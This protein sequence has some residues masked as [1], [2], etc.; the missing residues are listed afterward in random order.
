MSSTSASLAEMHRW[1]REHYEQMVELGVFDSEPRVE[2]I[3]GYIID[4][5]P[6]SSTHAAVVH[7]VT[8]ALDRVFGQSYYSI[9]VQAPLALD[10]ESEPEPDIA[11][12]SGGPRDYVDHHPS[13]AV[14]VVEVAG[15]SLQRD[16]SLK[17]SLYAR[18][19]IQEYWIINLDATCLEI[20]RQPQHKNNT[21][22]EQ[23]TLQAG[24]SISPVAQPECSI[25]IV[26]LLP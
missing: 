2:L 18:N 24:D 9:R 15:T 22:Q 20:Y 26:D 23:L 16:Q 3:E 14:L 19:K 13:S 8:E 6:Q 1:D 5:A 4:M 12:V 21:Y 10:D 25:P 11:V 17:K 7:L